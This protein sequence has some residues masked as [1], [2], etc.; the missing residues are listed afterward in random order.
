M[1]INKNLLNKKPTVILEI[2]LS[3]DKDNRWQAQ[4]G[5]SLLDGATGH[6]NSPVNAIR[7]LCDA[8]V[9][10]PYEMQTFTLK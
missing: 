2:R 1:I 4:V 10:N 6:G 3:P 7:D 9:S 5:K 8:L